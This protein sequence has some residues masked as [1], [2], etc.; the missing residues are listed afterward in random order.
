[1]DLIKPDKTTLRIAS[2]DIGKK[3]FAQYV[4]DSDVATLQKLEETYDL[5]PQKLKRKC[6][7]AMN[8]EIE[9]I[10]N[11]LYLNS[12]RVQ[13]GVYDLRDDKTSDNL[14]LKTRINLLSHLESY[15]KIWDTCDIFI[16]EQ[17]YFKTWGGSKKGKSKKGAGTEA[18]VDAIKIAEAT[19]M[20]FLNAYPFKK[21]MYFGSQNKTQIL[22]APIK[23]TKTERKNWAT[24][25]SRNIHELREDYGMMELF[26][27]N[28]LVFR[29]RL[30]TEKLIEKYISTYPSEKCSK[31]CIELVEKIVRYRQK[32]D[33]VGDSC[34]QCQA[35]KYRYLVAKF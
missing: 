35:F 18:N 19:F 1:M 3:N 24:D 28:D 2:F 10:L 29:K 11:Q 9:D 4:E 34:V 33:D 5:L 20:W 17:Q 8:S 30:N 23:M 14:D 6:S 27:L 32:L 15:T 25:K 26:K 13:T 16:I 7:G 22:G 31:D 21:I 12:K